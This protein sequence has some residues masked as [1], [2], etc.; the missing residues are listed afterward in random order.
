VSEQN[1]VLR[2]VIDLR[3]EKPTATLDSSSVR[4]KWMRWLQSSTSSSVMPSAILSRESSF[5]N[6]S[7]GNG[8]AIQLHER[9]SVARAQMMAFLL[10]NLKPTTAGNP[11][12]PSPY[13]G[14]RPAS[15]RY[16]I[17][18]MSLLSLS[19][20]S[21]S[22]QEL[23]TLAGVSGDA[24]ECASRLFTFESNTQETETGPVLCDDQGLGCQFA[25]SQTRN[26]T[27]RQSLTRLGSN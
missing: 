20:A 13:D 27:M 1:A 24:S 2:F 26:A 4:Q 16:S 3:L 18:C 7:K 6:S 15:G 21:H 14:S 19:W 22:D 5:S 12:N 10:A 23:L 8:R 11:K 25:E 9:T 17:R